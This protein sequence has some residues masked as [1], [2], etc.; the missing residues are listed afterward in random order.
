MR[1]ILSFA[2]LTVGLALAS[3]TS[4]SAQ[5]MTKGDKFV[6]GSVSYTAQ[7]GAS[8]V[9]SVSPT[10]GYFVTKCFAVGATASFDNTESVSVGAFG[11]CYF[12][13]I[14]KHANIFSDLTVANTNTVGSPAMFSAGVGLGLNY[15]VTPRLAL[16]TRLTDLMAY[17]NQDGHS[18]FTLGVG[19]INNPI[20]AP[21]FGVLYKF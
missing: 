12:M 14:G 5:S 11:R 6:E 19:T 17:T 9:W 16:T 3:F 1:K 4:A 8:P 2:I 13:S 21:Q 10:V 7:N 20:A 15:F 18:K